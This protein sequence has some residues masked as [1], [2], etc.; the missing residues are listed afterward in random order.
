[1]SELNGVI[2]IN[3]P[4]GFT[5]FDVV[6]VM[7]GATGQRKIGHLGTLDPNATGVLP[8]VLG[9]AAKAQELI[10]NHNKGYTAQFQL[11]IKTDTL[12]IWGNELKRSDIRVSRAEAEASLKHFCGEIEQ[13]PPMYSAVQVD[14]KRLYDLARQGKTVDRP[15]RTVTVFELEL[16]DFDEDKQCGTLNILC[17]KGTYIRTIIDDL[18]E[19]LGTYAVMTSLVRTYA[20]GFTLSDSI[21]LEKARNMSDFSDVIKST[22]EL[23]ADLRFVRLSELQSKRFLNGAVID[24]NRTPLKTMS[25][26]EGELL[27]VKTPDSTFIGIARV[28]GEQLK[29]VKQ[30]V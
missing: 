16:V 28:K 30:F 15:K 1:M 24:I 3:K 29:K 22:E 17:S 21:E 2:V 25:P 26:N 6:A 23:F 18:G 27:R 20:C 11:G 13:T 8:L 7:R 4:Q 9:S 5:S 10:A 12:D 19:K 14:G